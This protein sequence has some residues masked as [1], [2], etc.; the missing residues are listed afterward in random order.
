VSPIPPN[1]SAFHTH[2]IARLTLRGKKVL[3]KEHGLPLLR[4]VP[5][6]RKPYMKD[7]GHDDVLRGRIQQRR[8]QKN[9]KI[10]NSNGSRSRDREVVGYLYC[11]LGVTSR[12]M[13]RTKVVGDSIKQGGQNR[14]DTNVAKRK[15]RS[16]LVLCCPVHEL[17]ICRAKFIPV[18]CSERNDIPVS[19][20][21]RQSNEKKSVTRRDIFRLDIGY[22]LSKDDR[23][24][25]TKNQRQCLGK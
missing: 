13:R 4:F 25:P 2:G 3:G 1:P 8:K 24:T 19:R 15:L 12:K 14:R 9:E 5:V 23:E 10:A 18:T 20:R 7:Y 16:F 11:K 22:V 21:K 6:L 17:T